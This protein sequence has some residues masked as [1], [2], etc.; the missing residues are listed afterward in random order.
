M[1]LSEVTLSDMVGGSVG[2]YDLL[3][4]ALCFSVGVLWAGSPVTPLCPGRRQDVAALDPAG[5]L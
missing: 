1:D 4:P 5:P 3:K 2:D